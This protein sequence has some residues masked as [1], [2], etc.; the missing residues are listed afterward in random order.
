MKICCKNL[1]TCYL[2]SFI[3]IL[4]YFISYIKYVYIQWLLTS[5]LYLRIKL[6]L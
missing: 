1:L 2:S 5:I 3:Y 6:Y 4:L